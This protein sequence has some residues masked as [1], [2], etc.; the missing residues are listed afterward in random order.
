M[1]MWVFRSFY[2]LIVFNLFLSCFHNWLSNTTGAPP[3]SGGKILKQ[4]EL[5]HTTQ[6]K[7]RLSYHLRPVII[8]HRNISIYVFSFVIFVNDL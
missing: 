5:T 1:D 7:L 6:Q 8:L 2:S 3:L 4:F